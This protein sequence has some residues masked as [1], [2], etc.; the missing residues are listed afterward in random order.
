[1]NATV[2][3][4]N[5]SSLPYGMT[6]ISLGFLGLPKTDTWEG[7]IVIGFAF[8]ILFVIISSLVK[9]VWHHIAIA[10]DVSALAY[11][12]N[13]GCLEK[14]ARRRCDDPTPFPPD[15][16]NCPI[17]PDNRRYY[18]VRDK[19]FTNNNPHDIVGFVVGKPKWIQNPL[20][21]GDPGYYAELI[22]LW[23]QADNLRQWVK[24]GYAIQLAN[25]LND[26]EADLSRLD[27]RYLAIA[28]FSDPDDSKSIVD[29]ITKTY[30]C[31]TFRCRPYKKYGFSGN[32]ID[33][34]Q[35]SWQV[36]STRWVA[37]K[38]SSAYH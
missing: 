19:T 8:P 28:P 11:L 15:F 4:G 25:L 7:A 22:I 33:T 16:E 18:Q 24:R 14:P 6:F 9:Y 38:V 32:E 20:H 27:S 29:A 21:G 3:H 30:E 12:G 36:A 10:H 34:R 31:R 35:L 17:Y 26:D 13:Y 1:M 23:H 37:Q 5:F 2:C